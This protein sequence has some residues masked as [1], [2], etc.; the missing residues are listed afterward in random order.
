[1]GLDDPIYVQ[2]LNYLGEVLQGDF[3]ASLLTSRPVTEDIARVFP[4][5]LELA[6]VAPLLGVLIGVPAGIV[7][8]HPVEHDDLHHEGIGEAA[9]GAGGRSGEHPSEL[10]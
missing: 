4:A 8:A 10:Q 2:F 3:G 9:I 1:M 5:T 6:T 7:A